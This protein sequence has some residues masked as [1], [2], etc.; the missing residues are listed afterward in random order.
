M[1]YFL[2]KNLSINSIINDKNRNIS[3]ALYVLIIRLL[4]L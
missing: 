3:F 2:Q 1:V 4:F